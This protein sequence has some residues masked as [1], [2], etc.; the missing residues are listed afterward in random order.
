MESWGRLAR[1]VRFHS[2]MARFRLRYLRSILFQ[3]PL[4]SKRSHVEQKETKV[5]KDKQSARTLP[6][7]SVEFAEL[8]DCDTIRRNT[9]V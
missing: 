7:Q 4:R 8:S 1:V 2:G 6:F 9:S 5:T 3:S